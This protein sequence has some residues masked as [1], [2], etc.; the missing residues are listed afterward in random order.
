MSPETESGHPN[1]PALFPL[2]PQHMS[3]SRSHPACS[4]HTSGPPAA[5]SED[6]RAGSEPTL[7]SIQPLPGSPGLL[8]MAA[9]HR[10]QVPPTTLWGAWSSLACWG[11]PFLHTPVHHANKRCP[12]R[13]PAVSVHGSSG[14]QP[15]PLSPPAWTSRAASFPGL[16]LAATLTPT[17]NTLRSPMTRVQ[18]LPP[19]LICLVLPL[20]PQLPLPP[21][22]WRAGAVAFASSRTH[23]LLPHGGLRRAV[24]CAAQALPCSVQLAPASPSDLSTL[25]GPYPITS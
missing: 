15:R 4:R 3:A 22:P 8:G 10:R 11:S 19:H 6:R 5:F 7:P 23:G 13:T 16:L 2:V 25:T 1:G 12:L 9:K 18:A 14:S 17:P 24:P 21:T 20:L